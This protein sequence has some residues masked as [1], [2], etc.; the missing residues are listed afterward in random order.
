MLSPEYASPPLSASASFGY[1]SSDPL[2]E[3]PSSSSPS[4]TESTRA[5]CP[6]PETDPRRLSRLAEYLSSSGISLSSSPEYS[7]PLSASALSSAFLMR[8]G[9][10]LD[11]GRCIAPSSFCATYCSAA[12]LR[13]ASAR[14]K[15]SLSAC[16]ACSVASSAAAAAVCCAALSFEALGTALAPATLS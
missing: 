6:E 10:T 2:S 16:F 8:L 7:S 11:A 12:S 9:C 3:T 13:S 5:V 15:A 14:S 4:L 1:G